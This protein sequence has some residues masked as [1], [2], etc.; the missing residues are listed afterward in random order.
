MSD[1][2]QNWPDLAHGLYERLTGSNAEITYDFQNME[3][4]IPAKIGESTQ[5]ARWRLNGV[6]KI[7]TQ[8]LNG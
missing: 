4:D 3:V 1:T 6:V 2:P 8:N 7:R 5:H